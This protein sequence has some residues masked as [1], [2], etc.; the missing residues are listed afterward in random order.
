MKTTILRAIAALS[1]AAA[2]VMAPTAA[3]AYVDPAVVIATPPVIPAGGQTVFTTNRPALQGDEDVLI[4]VSG[5]NANGIALASVVQTNTTLRSKAINGSLRVPVTV[6]QNASGR[7]DFTFTG[8][9][10]GTVL[11]GSVTVTGT[12]S[13]PAKGGLAVTGFDAGATTGV[14]I[15]GAGL[16]VAGGAVVVGAAIRRRRRSARS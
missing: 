11:H 16:V 4:S 3:N 8:A 9:R 5:V 12:P 10:S 7:Y 15:A 13:S 1:L 14:W 6:P 2:A